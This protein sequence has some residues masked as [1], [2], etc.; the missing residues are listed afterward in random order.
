MTNYEPRILITMSNI[1]SLDLSKIIGDR[2]IGY[3]D[4]ATAQ[5]IIKAG[6]MPLY[7]PTSTHLSPATINHYLDSADGIM[8]TGADTN[9]YPG[10]YDEVLAAPDNARIDN[11]R[12]CVDI[13]LAIQAYEQRIPM[14]GVCKGMQIIN[15][16]LGGSL[17][18]D[19]AS[20][21]ST[22]A[23]SSHGMRREFTH[24]ATLHE[25]S[26]L[27]RIFQSDQLQL[28]G[29]HSQA[30]KELSPKLRASATAAD[31]IIEA[32]EGIDHPF[33][34]G[35]QFHPELLADYPRYDEIIRLFVRACINTY[36]L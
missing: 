17:Y 5:A 30:I 28:N 1:D 36:S 31:G 21:H 7:M 6:G 27:A 25:G 16:G 3:S 9:V 34:L 10:H 29:A 8:L 4:H 22:V 33:L 2:A 20:T 24:T 26:F 11:A 35:A 13:Q 15:V 19:V 23:H 12:D 18:Q 14:L 32:Y